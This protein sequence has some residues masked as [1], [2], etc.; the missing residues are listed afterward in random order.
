[1]LEIIEYLQKNEFNIYIVSA[2]DRYQVRSVIDE[3]INIPKSN[4]IGTDYELASINQGNEIGYKYK[5]NKNEKLILKGE[6]IFLN[7][8]FN[9]INGI[10][11][12]IG[13]KPILVF[14][15]SEGDSS[16]AN[17]AISDNEYNSLAFMVLNDD[18][19]R[20][21]GNQ[22]SADKMKKLCDKNNWIHISMKNDWKTI[23]G[24]NVTRNN[25]I[26]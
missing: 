21:R 16:M 17:Y 26:Y 2:T 7:S 19:I 24:L 12:N 8:K 18:L 20:E 25:K 6:L 4:I 22:A 5:Y 15:N 14:G 11:R 10:I 13:R 1:M 9:K 23:Y 3:H